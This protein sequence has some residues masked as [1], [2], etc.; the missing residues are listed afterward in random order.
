[1]SICRFQAYE[2]TLRLRNLE[3]RDCGYDCPICIVVDLPSWIARQFAQ[4]QHF[5]N[6]LKLLN[7]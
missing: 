3:S 6:F 1:M 4:P 7:F 5:R 2:S